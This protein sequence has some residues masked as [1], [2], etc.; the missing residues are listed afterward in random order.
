[1]KLISLTDYVLELWDDKL[2]SEIGI[3]AINYAQ[4]LN[5]KIKLEMFVPCDEDG[6]V[7]EEP[8]I[9]NE[10][11][12]TLKPYERDK[13]QQAKERVL[14]EGF[15]I[16]KPNEHKIDSLNGTS[17]LQ[18]EEENVGFIKDWED[19]WYFEY[20]TIEDL[21][22]LNITLTESAIKKFEL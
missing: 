11:V 17:F 6:N 21:V 9:Y 20:E 14:F 7:L 12:S 19:T 2:M 4:F 13:Y 1:M 3:I 5:Q 18:N 10:F 8:L 22:K 15:K 16:I